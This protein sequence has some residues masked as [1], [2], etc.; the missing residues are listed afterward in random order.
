MNIIGNEIGL[1]ILLMLT[2]VFA[3]PVIFFGFVLGTSKRRAN[4][5]I[6]NINQIRTKH[7]TKF[8]GKEEFICM[9]CKLE[10][11]SGDTIYIC[12]QCKAHYHE[13]HFDDWF[14]I[15]TTCPVCEFNFV[16]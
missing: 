16:K 15:E 8:S 3:C 5:K 14:K 1:Y 13:D 4:M 2:S 6:K 12:P 7:R 10:I 9:I 11:C